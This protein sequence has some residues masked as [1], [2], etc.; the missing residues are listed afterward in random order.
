[1]RIDLPGGQVVLA[2]TSLKLLKQAV[3]ALVIWD[4]S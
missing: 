4:N 1:M 2:E 3:E